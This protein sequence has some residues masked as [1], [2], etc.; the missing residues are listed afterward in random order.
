MDPQAD[1]DPPEVPEDARKT[2]EGQ[3]RL[4]EELENQGEDP[5]APGLHQSRHDVADES[6]R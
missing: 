3:R 6:R 2:T 5:D 1:I 4:Q